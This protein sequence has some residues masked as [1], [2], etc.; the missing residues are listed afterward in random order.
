MPADFVDTP[1][2]EIEGI[3]AINVGAT[4]R[5]THAVLPG[6]IERSVSL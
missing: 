2:E 5:V 6:M 4:L 1:S 3:V